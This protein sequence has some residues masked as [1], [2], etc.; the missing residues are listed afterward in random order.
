V[1]VLAC[2]AMSR[3]LVLAL[4]VPAQA[5]G[6]AASKIE[7]NITMLL[8]YY[9]TNV[10]GSVLEEVDVCSQPTTKYDTN[11]DKVRVCMHASGTDFAWCTP[12]ETFQSHAQVSV[13]NG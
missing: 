3:L 5:I 10:R 1:S 9:E 4:C 13:D 7:Q 8:D 2:A 11:A 6:D 12:L